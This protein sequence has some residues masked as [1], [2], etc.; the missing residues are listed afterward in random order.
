M[1]AKTTHSYCYQWNLALPSQPRVVQHTRRSPQ[2]QTWF[3]GNQDFLPAKVGPG[4]L[5]IMTHNYSLHH[6]QL[7]ASTHLYTFHTHTERE[8]CTKWNSVYVCEALSQDP[9]HL[10]HR[11]TSL[12]NWQTTDQPA[13][14]RWWSVCMLASGNYHEQRWRDLGDCATK[15]TTA[16]CTIQYTLC[17][18]IGQEPDKQ[19]YTTQP[20]DK[21]Y[22]CMSEENSRELRPL[23]MCTLIDWTVIT[24]LFV[25]YS[26]RH[27]R[28]SNDVPICNPDTEYSILRTTHKRRIRIGR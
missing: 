18:L 4:G 22:R 21:R 15:P 3:P 25:L 5:W 11:H 6:H 20:I 10:L 28:Q 24:R 27:G 19:L 9:P 26:W 17:S 2:L 16:T 1:Q 12:P 23:C 14:I 8:G 7:Q 13:T